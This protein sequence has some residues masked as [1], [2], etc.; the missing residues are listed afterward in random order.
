MSAEAISNPLPIFLGLNGLP[1]TGGLVYF[2]EVGQDPR[3]APVSVYWDEAMT[4][5]A[6]QPLI[7]H[8]GYLYRNGAP[9]MA[10]CDSDYSVLVLDS[11]GQQVFY[12]ASARSSLRDTLAGG[13][14]SSLIGTSQPDSDVVRMLDEVLSDTINVKGYG[15]KGD[16]TTDDSDAIIA[17]LTYAVAHTPC[18]VVFPRGTYKCNSELGAFTA[19]NLEIDLQGSVLDFSGTASSIAPL[20]EITGTY[21][22]T[23]ALTSNQTAGTKTVACVSSGFAVGDMVRV[24][25]NSI[26]DSTRTSTKIGELSFVETVPDAASLT[27]T[28]ETQSSYTTAASAT[29]Q[30]LTPVRNVT[31]KNGSVYGPSTDDGRCGIRISLGMGCLV[32]NVRFFNIDR[33]HL[34]F[35]DCIFSKARNCHFEHAKHTSQAYGVSFIDACQDCS[36]IGNSFVDVRHSLSTNNNVSSSW[37]ITRRILFM[38]N[39]VSDSAPASGGSGGDAIDTHA[40]SEEI[41]ITGNTVNSSSGNGINFEART[42]E[43]SNN[44]IKYVAVVGININP[45]ADTTSSVTVTGNTLLNVGDSASEYGITVSVATADMANCVVSGNRVVSFAQ[46]LR[47]SATSPYKVT[48]ATVAGNSA[49]VSSASTTLNGIEVNRVDYAA[50]TGNSVSAGAQG[51]TLT[52]CNYSTVSGNAVEIFN[53]SGATGYGVRLSG[54]C[55]TVNVTGNTLRYSASGITDTTGVSFGS[56]ATITN[57][58]ADNNIVSGFGRRTNLSSGSGCTGFVGSSSTAYDAGSLAD[59]AGVTTTVTV[60][61]A[62]LGDYAVASLGV[63]LQGITLSAWVSATDTVSVRLQNESGGTIDLANTNIRA[64]VTRLL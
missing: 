57:C 52:D 11:A 47:I 36:A 24:Y 32:E 10:W 59:G 54:T 5:P 41:F 48:R 38:G 3:T 64:K 61:G 2:G 17:A 20:L 19:D 60:T 27:L 29:I 40:G 28:T 43:V 55:D 44:V 56:G 49:A 8:S 15:A 16:G 22:S 37:G 4:I 23:A 9:A 35:Q 62:T 51:I 7:T 12:S 26:W 42:G 25:S 13:S 18:R 46:P 53:T 39:T 50:I 33:T 21:G 31:I 58:N 14:G 34:Q 45:R 30:K 63:D 1:M 6:Q